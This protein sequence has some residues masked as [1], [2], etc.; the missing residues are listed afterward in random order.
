VAA[1]L[2]PWTP[3]LPTLDLLVSV[4]EL[5]SLGRAAAAHGISQPSASLR[6][7]RLERRLGIAVLVRT[8]RGSQLTPAGQAVVAW[9]RKVI[10]TA[11]ALT[12]GI[13]ALQQ[14]R[15]A[16]MRVAASLT[17]AEYLLP[18]WLL[19]LRRRN[20]GAEVAVSVAN[21]HDVCARIR[22]GE[23]DLGLI[24]TPTLP[25]DLTATPIGSDRLVL[26]V[27]PD[28]PLAA[29]ATSALPATDIPELPLLIRETGSGTRDTF[30]TA[31]RAALPGTSP[32]PLP[33]ASELGSTTTILA[34]ARAG[35]GVGVV[36]TLAAASDL[37][38]GA[39][40]E[41]P[42]SQLPLDRTLHAVWLGEHPTLLA[43]D[44]IQQ[45]IAATRPN[46]PVL[47][48]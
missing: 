20:P 37:A 10:A 39:L 14:D 18:T 2:P 47:S 3:D 48:Q 26:V 11:T 35:G 40:V 33:Y 12:D 13:T 15:A 42:V 29:K 34:T 9:A 6:L 32:P 45:A 1:V 28:Y 19:R 5:G 8:S 31:L 17:I 23:A 46:D 43:I 44:L 21:S 4:A 22:S 38:A 16:R 30:F 24:E 25:T 41:I 36:S 27:S 7:S